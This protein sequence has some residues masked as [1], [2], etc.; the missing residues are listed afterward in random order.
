MMCFRTSWL[1]RALV[2]AIVAAAIPAMAFAQTTGSISENVSAQTAL[3]ILPAVSA[4]TQVSV[5]SR[6]ASSDD[7][8]F[9]A[10]FAL[11]WSE[12]TRFKD[13]DCSST[14][15]AALYG[16]GTGI[17]AAPLGSL[18]DF[19][20]MAGFELGFGRVVV[21]ALRLEAVIQH[22]PDFSFNGRANFVQTAERQAVS[23]D[24]SSLSGMFSAYMDLPELGLPRLGP[25]SPFIGGGVGLSRI[26]IDETHMEF[27]RTTT[28]VPGGRRINLAWMLTAGVATS[29]TENLTLDVA[30]YY[31]DSGTVETGRA[32]GRVVWRDGS[33]D[34]LEIDL[35]GTRAN[36]S[37]HGLRV[38][39]RYS[40]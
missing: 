11:D 24:L 9:R 17:D 16:C 25:F 23:A 12:E 28:I 8:Y 39:L 7:F 1:R 36:L 3:F 14:S 21:P 30:W 22:R 29:L 35:A 19:G 4:D 27:A 31:T 33:R 26:D 18:G 34:P 5:P 20:T 38:S 13:K 37:S 2:V 10:G 15:P 32:K 6:A 40:F